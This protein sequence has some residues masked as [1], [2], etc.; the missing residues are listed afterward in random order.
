MEA[1]SLSQKLLELIKQGEDQT[2]QLL[3]AKILSDF[4]ETAL[5][6]IG[7]LLRQVEGKVRLKILS[8][9][10]EDGATD[11]IPLFA[12][13]IREERNT[14]YAKSMITL[15]GNFKQKEAL[16]ALEDLEPHLHPDLKTT[17]QRIIG[18][19]R[20]IFREAFYMDEFVSGNNK[21]MKY[22]ANTMIREPDPEYIPFLNNI[23]LDSPE[24]HMQL[25][26]ISVLA[27]IGD[28]SSLEACFK[29]LETLKQQ[30]AMQALYCEFMR[31][32]EAAKLDE[33]ETLSLMSQAMDHENEEQITA[34]WFRAKEERK[35]EL[36]PEL[37]N[38]HFLFQSKLMADEN[39][40]FWKNLVL[41]SKMGRADIN[42]MNNALVM[43]LE[44]LKHLQRDTLMAMGQI[45][46][47][48]KVDNLIERLEGLLPSEGE[49]RDRLLIAVLS[50]NRSPDS[51]AKLLEY[52]AGDYPNDILEKVINALSHYDFDSAPQG[53]LQVA[54][55]HE[56]TPLRRQTQMMLGEKGFAGAL[57]E[58][59]LQNDSLL[60][61]S[62]AI[63]LIGE[64]KVQEGFAVLPSLLK[65]KLPDSLRIE[66]FKAMEE[67]PSAE[68]GVAVEPFIGVQN[69]MSI[70]EGALRC[71]IVAGGPQRLEKINAMMEGLNDKKFLEMSDPL[72]TLLLAVEV[73]IFE[74]MFYPQRAL[75]CKI[76]SLENNRVREKLLQLFE[77]LHWATREPQAW[78]TDIQ[79]SIH[80]KK[81]GFS[82]LDE[83]RLRA[84]IAKLNAKMLSLAKSDQK[85]RVLVE[86]LEMYEKA[87]HNA[88]VQAMRK[89]NVVYKADL[90]DPNSDVLPR[91]VAMVLNFIDTTIGAAEMTALGTTVAGRIGHPKL[92][93]RVE[94][95]LKHENALI[96]KAAHKALNLA[97]VDPAS[98][99]RSIV[100]VD[101]SR[102]ITKQLGSVLSKAGYQVTT[103]NKPLAALALLKNTRFD[104]LVLD[105]HMPEMDGTTLLKEARAAQCVPA[106]VLIITSSR[107]R[108]E[109]ATVVATGIE[110]IL[111]KPFPM[112]DLL[113][114]IKIMDVE[115]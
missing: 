69:T 98:L 63:S 10:I 27:E 91:L 7:E 20:G 40:S 32:A 87:D 65:Q 95:F 21:R 33:R 84:V 83:R 4:R 88:K 39:T 73:D 92:K 90:I 77:K 99:I 45:A 31:R 35:A 50:G 38:R 106:H 115:K 78:I 70:R 62:E 29:V 109:L 76:L 111:L 68:V 46:L 103:E 26:A 47:K 57:I 2:L 14:L 79:S 81:A 24:T 9:L 101:D 85:Q 59:L 100:I 67:F 15:F 110:G 25:E 30:T 22:A 11:L 105:L 80:N 8:Y 108:D 56:H 36:M 44:Q 64:Y 37:I 19:F 94:G 58:P 48:F 114:R 28:E 89:L 41:G 86:L 52:S 104:V 74:N 18:R 102:Y 96:A 61:R 82:V 72:M 16:R 75:W 1:G 6:E 97:F 5:E 54:T 34:L 71:M 53:L 3:I 43:Y 23:L 17:F 66:T 42:K 49:E 93:E 12:E 113:N 112:A 51:K 60:L 13:R 107:E 55:S